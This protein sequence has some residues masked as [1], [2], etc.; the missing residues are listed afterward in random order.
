MLEKTLQRCTKDKVSINLRQNNVEQGYINPVA[1]KMDFSI[2]L[3]QAR[4]FY[5]PFEP[6][7]FPVGGRLVWLV[8]GRDSS[9]ATDA[10]DATDDRLDGF[11]DSD[12]FARGIFTQI[13]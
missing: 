12:I 3:I 13:P 6:E 11:T 10:T 5:S 4:K 2:R 7:H 9:D 1:F 8:F